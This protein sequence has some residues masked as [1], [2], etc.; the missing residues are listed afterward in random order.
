MSDGPQRSPL[1]LGQELTVAWYRV[2]FASAFGALTHYRRDAREGWTEHAYGPHPDER[3][4][5]LQAKGRTPRGV[6]VFI[7]GGGWMMGFKEFYSADLEHFTTEGYT[8]F[9]LEYPKAPEHPHP[10]M[11]RSVLLALNWIKQEFGVGNAHFAGDSAGAN[12]AVMAAVLVTNPHL[13]AALGPDFAF[14]DVPNPLSCTGLYGILDR[15]S[16]MGGRVPGG[17]SML[18]AYGGPHALDETVD[19]VHAITPMDLKFTTHPPCF[20]AVGSKDVLLESSERYRD[21]LQKDGHDVSFKV[22][23]KAMHGFLSFP[24]NQ[25]RLRLIDDMLAFLQ[26]VGAR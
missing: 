10:Y 26:S 9:N 15:Q 11:L 19:L 25:R 23:G 20:L 17:E 6:L 14:P 8:V 12:L 4:D 2:M 7:H 22:Y 18:V 16:C 13:R 24:R 1:T 21:R 5:V 3:L